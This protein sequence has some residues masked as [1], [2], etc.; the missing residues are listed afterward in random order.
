MCKY[1]KITFLSIVALVSM[2]GKADYVQTTTSGVFTYYLGSSQSF[3][4][5][6]KCYIRKIT[7]SRASD[8]N[9]YTFPT[10]M[11]WASGGSAGAKTPTIY[12]INS[13]VLAGNSNLKTVT[14]PWSITTIGQPCFKGCVNLT[15]IYIS[16][17]NS[18]TEYNSKDGVLYD[19]GFTILKKYPEGKTG[20]TFTVPS[21]VTQLGTCCLV[22]TKL[23][24]LY[25]QGDAPAYNDDSFTDSNFTIY[26]PQGKSGWTNP[27]NGRPAYAIPNA[28]TGLSS[29]L[30]AS[31]DYVYLYWNPNSVATSYIVYRATSASGTKVQIAT[32]SGCNYKDTTATPGTTYWYY[33]SAVN[34]SCTGLSS[35]SVQ[36]RRKAVTYVITYAPGAYGIGSQVSDE[37]THDTPLT[38]RSAIFSRNGY[39][40]TGWAPKDGARMLYP[41]GFSYTE[42]AAITLYPVWT[43]NKYMITYLPGALGIGSQQT[44]TKT[45]GVSVT[46]L[47]A[48]FTRTGYTQTG[49][50]TTENGTQ[51]YPL[52]AIYTSNSALT[53]YPVW[54][55]NTYT[56]TY[57]SGSYGA[58]SQ[59][60]ETKTHGI[61][62]TLK[63]A[64][65]SRTGYSQSG[66]TT[67][68]GG[69]QEYS[70]GATYIS[71]ESTT[72]YPTWTANKYT[73]IFDSNGGTGTM[74][75]T[76]AEYDTSFTVPENSFARKG[77]VFAGWATNSTMASHVYKSN[78]SVSNL[79]T[80]ANDT[81]LFYA[82]WDK[83]IV[84]TPTVSPATG[85]TFK[86]DSCTVKILC[87][88]EGAVIYYSTDG[89]SPRALDVFRYNSEFAIT[90]TTTIKAFA[91]KDE[92]KSGLTT[93]V[94]TKINPA[95]VTLA[96]ALSAANIGPI[97]TGGDASWT[98]ITDESAPI[99]DISAQS[100]ITGN[101]TSSYLQTKVKGI[102]T[103]T[104]WWK[105]SCEPDE[106]GEYTY[107]H[108]TLVVDGIPTTHR[109][110]GESDW[111]QVSYTFT[112]GDEHTIRWVYSTD[113]Y[114]ASGY[115]DCAWVN[116]VTWSGEDWPTAVDPIPDIGDTPS[117]ADVA[118][119]VAGASDPQ[120]V[121]KIDATNYNNFRDW[122][123]NVKTKDGS[124]AGVRG[125]M[126][127][128]TAWF[129]YALGQSTLLDA[130]P[131][132]K[133]LSIN[134]FEPTTEA[135]KLDFTVSVGT[136]Q[137]G[138][139]AAKENLKKVFGLEGAATLDSAAFSPDNVDIEFGTPIDGKV[140]FTARPNSE[141]TNAKTFFMKVKMLP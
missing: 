130:A 18:T 66:W 30:D 128:D 3:D 69:S 14:I 105:T 39:C 5:L 1:I 112:N 21:T 80:V 125:V 10:A 118:A 134:A 90:A 12:K 120:I 22:N 141:N 73:I 55:A 7:C 97:L 36:G 28:V 135:G 25:F 121:K 13:G 43:P 127:A 46:L 87:E 57:Q 136:I 106:W 48:T 116:G 111:E 27:F 35:S 86:T 114:A 38:L 84:S 2:I 54:T 93:V 82:T 59:Q 124:D 62:Q 119:A 31:N 117:A 47:G 9:N 11:T 77:Y 122:A 115:S 71:N 110:D 23:S 96:S 60:T 44:A 92:V 101:N 19:S 37:K 72:L 33:V 29:E 61:A 64:V 34:E 88:T 83:L 24:S 133:D 20:T 78:E 126:N 63:G 139:T 104:F 103:L 129:S 53:L 98:A 26:Y 67:K 137:V 76:V 113:A 4:N 42:N 8:L 15:S 89:T 51:A 79:T 50:T 74:E 108:I 123:L 52:G 41:L 81:V 68:D 32:T 49:W 138:Q 17:G 131:T 75:N 99:G 100:G 16:G 95:P 65:F 6:K 107:D 94:I 70:L 109:L 132:D 45:Y 91:I 40:Q 56:I 58:G 85:S 140:K 102:G